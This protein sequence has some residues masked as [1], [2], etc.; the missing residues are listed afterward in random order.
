MW[1]EQLPRINHISFLEK[2]RSCFEST[3]YRET[4]FAEFLVGP[5]P[6]FE[7]GFSYLNAKTYSWMP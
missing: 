1:G 5:P 3:R 6:L 2:N 7:R 4:S